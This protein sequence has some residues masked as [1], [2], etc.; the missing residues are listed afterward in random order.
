MLMHQRMLHLIIQHKTFFHSSYNVTLKTQPLDKNV[1]GYM[2]W[3]KTNFQDPCQDRDTKIYTVTNG[4]S[5]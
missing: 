2:V 5:K 4:R 1:Q 3:L